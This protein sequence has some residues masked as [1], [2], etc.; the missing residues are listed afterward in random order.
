MGRNE[1]LV[2]S[3]TLIAADQAYLE[4]GGSMQALVASLLSS[5]SFLYRKDFDQEEK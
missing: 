5:D 3:P 1:T 4:S 2:D